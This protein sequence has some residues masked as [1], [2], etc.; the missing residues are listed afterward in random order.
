MRPLTRPAAAV[1]AK[2]Y[3]INVDYIRTRK[4]KKENTM[5]QIVKAEKLADKIYLCVVKAPWVAR[6]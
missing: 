3:R 4:Q 5:Y 1:K 6:S 2:S